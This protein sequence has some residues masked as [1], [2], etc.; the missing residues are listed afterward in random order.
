MFVIPQITSASEIKSSSKPEA[1]TAAVTTALAVFVGPATRATTQERRRTPRTVGTA[2][3]KHPPTEKSVAG[4]V[5]PTD[6]KFLRNVNAARLLMNR[7]QIENMKLAMARYVSGNG[8]MDERFCWDT[9]SRM[10][11]GC[12]VNLYDIDNTPLKA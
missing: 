12:R 3:T 9:T 6:L 11:L 8:T 4:K 5:K 7:R 2:A 1:R 10:L